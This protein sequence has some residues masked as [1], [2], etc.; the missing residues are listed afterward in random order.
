M[1]H[2]AHGHGGRLAASFL[3][4]LTLPPLGAYGG[5]LL[6]PQDNAKFRHGGGIIGFMAGYAIVTVIDIAI[7]G[8]SDDDPA[9]SRRV[10][11]IGGK[12]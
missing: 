7:A 5:Y 3:L 12:F 6:S 8:A 11:S 4:R 1:L 2:G 9:A 10:F